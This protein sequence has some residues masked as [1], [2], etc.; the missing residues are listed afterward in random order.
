TS[1]GLAIDA[2]ELSAHE[3]TRS[4]LLKAMTT[5]H[6]WARFSSYPTRQFTDLD[7][8]PD[9][10][11]LL[12]A[13]KGP[14]G[15]VF[16]INQD[17]TLFDLEA[18]DSELIRA[19]F[20]KGGLEIVTVSE[21]GHV[22]R[23]TSSGQLLGEQRL[24]EELHGVIIS[25]DG[26]LVVGITEAGE[27]IASVLGEE[28]P[29]QLNGLDGSGSTPLQEVALGNSDAV[30]V[31]RDEGGLVHVWS[32]MD[33]GV[34]EQIEF[35]EPAVDIAVHPESS[36]LAVLLA[37]GALE[38]WDVETNDHVARGR[39]GEGVKGIR[40]SGSGEYL[41]SFG[42]RE[43]LGGGGTIHIWKAE[44]LD[45]VTSIQGES[46]FMDVAFDPAGDRLAAC[47]GGHEVELFDVHDGSRLGSL[48]NVMRHTG[49]RWSQDG[50]WLAALSRS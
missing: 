8:S 38:L 2:M 5:H 31:A 25:E 29:I 19:S 42:G 39:H 10:R 18:H 9:G 33:Y 24:E 45:P 36:G 13:F 41:A 49:L 48:V 44:S 27:A 22:A 30:V 28:D 47:D 35:E 50:K 37:D 26:E 15:R 3:F 12:M 14:T 17:E 23:W 4:T 16:D 1:L 43:E 20:V 40:F 11:L 21:D 32:T 6:L 7:I 46:S 34:H